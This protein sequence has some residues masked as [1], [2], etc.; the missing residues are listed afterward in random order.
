MKKL[1]AGV[2]VCVAS[3]AHAYGNPED[4]NI[5]PWELKNG[6]RPVAVCVHYGSDGLCQEFV[7]PKEDQKEPPE[8][9][10]GSQNRMLLGEPLQRTWR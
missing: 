1:L 2:M 8:I 6:P 4:D 7:F 10:K 9:G 3:A 5:M